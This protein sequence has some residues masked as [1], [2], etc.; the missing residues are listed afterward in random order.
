MMQMAIEH[1]A[2]MLMAASN[3]D[4]GD[5]QGGVRDPSGIIGGYRSGWPMKDSE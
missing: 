1:G 2:T 4:F 3:M 5:R